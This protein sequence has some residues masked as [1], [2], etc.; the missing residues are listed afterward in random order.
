MKIKEIVEKIKKEREIADFK[1]TAEMLP[2]VRRSRQDQI[3]R[4]KENLKELESEYKKSLL[5]QAVF[6]V[7]RGSQAEQFA[8]LATKFGCFNV[9]AELFYEAIANDVDGRYYNGVQSSPALFDTVMGNFAEVCSDIGVES[10]PSVYYESKYSRRLNNKEDLVSL[11]MQAYN[12]KVGAEIAGIYAVSE[13][14]KL[15]LEQGV[16]TDTVAIVLYTK[17]KDFSVDLENSLKN[18]T[19]RVFLVNTTK[20][21][22][23]GSVEKVFLKIKSEI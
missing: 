5:K 9:R 17:N 16:D 12:E 2:S 14:A 21:S 13:V 1:I 23:A 15:G 11:L 6:I 20:V 19:K 7:T 22:T 8:D 3:R 4:A 10:A 18:L